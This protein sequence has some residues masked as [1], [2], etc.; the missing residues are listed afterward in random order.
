[1]EG[2]KMS[3]ILITGAS[4]GF[5]EVTALEFARQGHTVYA[6]LRDPKQGCRLQDTASAQKLHVNL[7]SL[8]VTEP[9]SVDSA[10]KNILA[11]EQRLDVLVNNAGI[12]IPGALEDMPEAHLRSVMDT[13]FFGVV[14]MTRAVLPAMRKQKSGRIIML[15][16]VGGLISRAVDSIYCA[17]K[18][19]LE[20]MSE[21]LRYE[22]ARFGIKVSVI[23]PGVFR[24]E[25]GS[26][27][28]LPRDYPQASPYHD[29][30]EFR[31]DKV[32]E[33]VNE[34]DD[35]QQVADLIVDV[36]NQDKPAFRYPA[37][38][39]AEIFLSRLNRMDADE[40]DEAIRTAAEI[41]WW[42][43]GRNPP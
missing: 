43:E 11:A 21:G 4:S 15:S 8:D 9:K 13:N 38:Q 31:I 23:E 5:G 2:V 24:T 22:V 20:G 40:R 1:M 7:L 12:H 26:K 36:A 42:L 33:A 18:W 34:G 37:G 30:L 29:L 32:A 6:T 14:N 10:I 35:P 16:S 3:V 17:S 39:Q 19:A 27:Y 41:D 28:R 25:I